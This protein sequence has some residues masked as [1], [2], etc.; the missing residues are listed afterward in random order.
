MRSSAPLP[1]QVPIRG[2]S[3]ILVGGSA[4]P[5]FGERPN[6][7]TRAVSQKAMGTITTNSIRSAVEAVRVVCL[8]DSNRLPRV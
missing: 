3:A 4:N 7:P 8:Y 6:W 5:G 2:R 1:I